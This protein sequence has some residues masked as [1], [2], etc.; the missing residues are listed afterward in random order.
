MRATSV[1][2]DE[3]PLREAMKAVVAKRRRGGRIA[4]TGGAIAPLYWQVVHWAMRK[5]RARRRDTSR[6]RPRLT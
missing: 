6:L 5:M 1:H 4:I 2:P 3:E